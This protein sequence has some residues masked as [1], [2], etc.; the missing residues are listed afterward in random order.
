MSLHDLGFFLKE[1]FAACPG[2][3]DVLVGWVKDD[4]ARNRKRADEDV[5][6]PRIV[7]AS[8]LA[9]TVRKFLFLIT[10]SIL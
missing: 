8:C 3:A 2:S 5:G 7:I 6:V 9:M 1:Q 4:G 10:V